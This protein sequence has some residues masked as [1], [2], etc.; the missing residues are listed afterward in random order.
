MESFKKLVA[1]AK[2]KKPI[3]LKT[4]QA[5]EWIMDQGYAAKESGENLLVTKGNK[6]EI[7]YPS[8]GRGVFRISHIEDAFDDLN[9]K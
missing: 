7:V 2:K 8:I 3:A 9:R 4:K 1:E 5:I 6:S